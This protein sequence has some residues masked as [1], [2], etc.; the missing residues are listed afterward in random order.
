MDGISTSLHG[1]NL[2]KETK[3]HPYQFLKNRK[4]GMWCEYWNT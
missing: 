4:I 3:S 2:S 1:G